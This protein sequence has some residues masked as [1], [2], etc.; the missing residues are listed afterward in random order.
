MTFL[1]CCFIKGLQL[2]TE[3]VDYLSNDHDY[4]EYRHTLKRS[5]IEFKEV[6]R[7]FKRTEGGGKIASIERIQNPKIYRG[8]IQEKEHIEKRRLLEIQESKHAVLSI[9]GFH[10]TDAEAVEQIISNGFNRSYAGT[11]VGRLLDST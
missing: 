1:L 9:R 5:D 6:E 3:W 7:A 11:A 2:P 4:R 8:F 10:G